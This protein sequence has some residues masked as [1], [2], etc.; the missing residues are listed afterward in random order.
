MLSNIVLTPAEGKRL[1]AGALAQQPDVRRALE[2]GLVVIHPSSTTAFLYQALTGAWPE[3]AWVFGAMG[4]KGLCRSCPAMLELGGA[5]PNRVP[6][7]AWLFKKGV[8]QPPMSLDEIFT[9]MTPSD[10][11]IKGANAVDAEGRAATLT[12]NP[13]TGGTT[14]KL[15][16]AWNK[17]GF[18]VYI[19]V[20]V[21]KTVPVPIP[22]LLEF[23][24]AEKPH[25]S[26]GLS[27]GVYPAVGTVYREPEALE[28]M[29][30]VRAVV[31]AAGGI[32][33]AEGAS[34]I[35]LRGGE[36][37]VRGAL[38]LVRSLKGTVLPPVDLPEL[39]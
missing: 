20:G 13:E 34:V 31:G 30:R 1:I 38:D 23:L 17:I 32:N 33:G 26:M 24:G 18:H 9:R 27:C 14:G 6:R 39:E 29:F 21:E 5:D 36:K 11:Y 16:A 4:P 22:R 8:L 25:P 10:V 35:Y 15:T 12:S 19:P 37:E 2:R 3:G 28:S 7:K